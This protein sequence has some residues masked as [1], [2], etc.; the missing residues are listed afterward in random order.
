VFPVGDG[1]A[2]TALLDQ[3]LARPEVDP[4]SEA[5]V[6]YL[7]DHRARSVARKYLDVFA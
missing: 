3:C 5:K 7:R 1:A 6:A 4:M 2:L